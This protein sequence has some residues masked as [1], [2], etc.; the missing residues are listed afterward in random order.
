MKR[1]FSLLMFVFLTASAW[2]QQYWTPKTNQDYPDDNLYYV[3]VYLNGMMADDYDNVEV[4]A[5]LND[6]CRASATVSSQGVASL[7]VAGD[8]ASE[9]GKNISFKVRYRNLTYAVA[10]KSTDALKAVF[11]NITTKPSSAIKLYVDA[12]TDVKM[13]NPIEVNA[14]ATA[15]PYELNLMD[16][17]A[18]VYGDTSYVPKNLSVCETQLTTSCQVVDPVMGSNVSGF[19]YAN[20]I[21]TIEKAVEGSFNCSFR[22][23]TPDGVMVAG[24]T[25]TLIVKLAE[26]PVT[27]MTVSRPA[28]SIFTNDNLKDLLKE[29]VTITPNNATHNDFILSL[30][31]TLNHS[32]NGEKFSKGGNYEVV[33][34]STDPKYY[35]TL[36]VDVNV[37]EHPC[38]ISGPEADLKVG[39]GDY[40]DDAVMKNIVLT[41]VNNIDKWFYD[42]SLDVKVVSGAEFMDDAHVAKKTGTVV[43]EVR[44]KNGLTDKAFTTVYPS[45]AVTV[46]VNIVSNLKVF[47]TVGNAKFFKNGQPSTSTPVVVSVSNPKN[48]PFDKNLL[49]ISF[50]DRYAGF[51]YAE[52]V[53]VDDYGYNEMGAPIAYSFTI[54]PKFVGRDIAYKVT[55][56][57]QPVEQMGDP[58][59]PSMPAAALTIAGVE[60][61]EQGWN[62]M[63]VNN[64]ADP[65][66]PMAVESVFPVLNDIEQV[67]SQRE[68]VFNDSSWGLFG[69]LK[70]IT[71]ANAMYK[72]NALNA[73]TVNMGSYN[74]FETNQAGAEFKKGYNWTNNPCEFDVVPSQLNSFLGFTPSEGDII[75]TQDG[76][77]SY[78]FGNWM[79]DSTFCLKAGKG[80]I[81]FLNEN[82]SMTV[83]G[84][85]NSI[86]PIKADDPSAAGKRNAKRH[87]SFFSYNAH[88]FA[89]KMAMI[90]RVE[91]LTDA[92]NYEVGVFVGDECRGMGK[93]VADDILFINAVGETGEMMT[94]KLYNKQTGELS[95]I[96][97]AVRCELVNGSITA[98]TLLHAP[99]ATGIHSIGAGRQQADTNTYDLSG[100]RVERATK[101]LYIKAGKTVLVK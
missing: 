57:G 34:R 43:Y 35:K 18:F 66:I 99:Q 39:L 88:A 82:R 52:M 12:I 83:S 1:L 51:P 97:E 86:K 72:V 33:I 93:V 90:A 84:L 4:G 30:S 69:D 44:V 26:I 65:M 40:V 22:A 101:G 53:S 75:I 80:F 59:Q 74:C 49:A 29:Y 28:F 41:H 56:D 55:Y 24:I 100:R 16:K 13:Q 25:S 58:S 27:N 5:F 96:D 47:F 64:I 79:A 31:D 61:L 48:E 45:D 11:N 9:S 70:T 81:Y 17:V 91:G 37:M 3:R 77:A 8:L 2:A 20:G 63:A 54:L 95:D 6:E 38:G 60:N 15:F 36:V 7:R 32:F 62:W 50:P 89:D 76:F 98:P 78:G 46:K 85:G 14:P 71:P 23:F 68:A 19:S 92:E 42:D 21:L 67:R 10:P 94:L 73:T 87:D